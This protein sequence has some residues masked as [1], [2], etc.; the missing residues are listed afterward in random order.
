[1]SLFTQNR[2]V[3]DFMVLAMTIAAAADGIDSVEEDAIFSLMNQL[4]RLRNINQQYTLNAAMDFIVQNGY[5]NSINYFS[6]IM[7]INITK[8]ILILVLEISMANDNVSLDEEDVI[9]QFA[10]AMDVDDFTL[11]KIVDVITWK[12]D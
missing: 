6:N 3:E 10:N 5:E 7:D 4:P 12:F 2:D 1:M 8:T 9:V 11:N